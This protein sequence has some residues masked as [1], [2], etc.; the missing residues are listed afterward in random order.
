MALELAPATG[1]TA[2]ERSPVTYLTRDEVERLRAAY[3]SDFHR[4][5]LLAREEL[6]DATAA[7]DAAIADYERGIADA[8]V[9]D[10]E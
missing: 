10:S 7:V 8:Q 5:L 3:G 9:D 6:R 2:T 1:Q 4:R